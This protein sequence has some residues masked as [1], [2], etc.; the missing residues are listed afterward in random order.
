MSGAFYGEGEGPIWLDNVR[1][2]LTTDMSLLECPHRPI[3]E[4]I[5]RTSC[6][7]SKDVGVQCRDDQGEVKNIKAIIINPGPVH[8]TVMISWEPGNSTSAGVPIMFE[9]ECNSES[10]SIAISVSNH[11]STVSLGGLLPSISYNCCVSAIYDLYTARRICTHAEIETTTITEEMAS[12]STNVIGGVLGFII[13][14][15]LVL[16]ALSGTLLIF[17]LRPQWKGR[18]RRI[19]ARYTK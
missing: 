16:L 9:I 4:T 12:N 5:N 19:L 11:S 6:N 7:H 8:S 1:C 15:L 18:L 13:A 3:S 10:H 14:V 17:Q 2:N